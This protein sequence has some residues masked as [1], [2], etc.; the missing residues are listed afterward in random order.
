MLQMALDCDSEC[1]WQ[2]VQLTKV[3]VVILIVNIWGNHVI[4]VRWSQNTLLQSVNGESTAGLNVVAF[5]FVSETQWNYGML[6]TFFDALQLA[7]CY[8]YISLCSARPSG[9]LV[10]YFGALHILLLFPSLLEVL[11]S[12]FKDFLCFLIRSLVFSLADSLS[13]FVFVFISSALL[14]SGE[15]GSTDRLDW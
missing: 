2:T 15:V 12:S 10:S 7:F 9:V 8:L 1:R 13:C 3:D 6:S 14:Q 5:G 11:T 4:L